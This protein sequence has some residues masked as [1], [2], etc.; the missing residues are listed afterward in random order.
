MCTD[1]ARLEESAARLQRLLET[2]PVEGSLAAAEDACSRMVLASPAASNG[3]IASK[4][5]EETASKPLAKRRQLL[6]QP[7]P[8]QL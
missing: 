3:A 1:R 4:V 6:A 5:E 2:A 8:S 7:Q